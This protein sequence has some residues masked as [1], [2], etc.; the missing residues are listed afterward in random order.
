MDVSLVPFHLVPEETKGRETVIIIV[1]VVVV[2]VVIVI[3]ILWLF[4]F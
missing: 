1:V 4:V 3:V 2:V